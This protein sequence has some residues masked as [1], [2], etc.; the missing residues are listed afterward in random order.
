MKDSR[1]RIERI[2]LINA[3]YL[4]LDLAIEDEALRHVK[5]GH[6]FLVRVGNKSSEAQTWNPYLRER[7]WPIGITGREELRVE[8]PN[9]RRYDVGQLVQLLGLI[10]QPYRFRKNLRNVLLIAYNTEPTSLTVMTQQL[11]AHNVNVTMVLL[12]DARAY[13]TNHLAPEIEVI[14]SNDKL[15]WQDMVMTLGWADQIFVAVGQDDERFRFS[16]V[17]GIIQSKRTDIPA[18]YV[19]G[20]FRPLLPCGVGACDACRIV[21]KDGTSTTCTEGPA[22]D[23]TTVRL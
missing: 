13:Q 16:E 3:H 23:L 15:E 5:A 1:A 18:Q 20:V 11:L 12:G 17:Y 21:L 2:S 7:W 6:S 14:R 22:Y 10:G 4:H 9:N 19:F 8:V